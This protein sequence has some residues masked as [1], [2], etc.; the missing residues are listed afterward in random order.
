MKLKLQ[1]SREA[2]LLELSEDVANEDCITGRVCPTRICTAKGIQLVHESYGKGKFDGMLVYRKGEWFILCNYS[3][4]NAEGSTRERFTIAHELGHYH[5]PEH[6]RQLMG[7]CRPHGSHAGVFDGAESIEELEA[8]TFAANLLMPPLRFAPRLRSGKQSPLETIVALR[9]EFDTSLE[10]T[11][12]QVMRH[13]NR[14][15]AIAKWDED[16]LAWHRISDPFFRETGYRQFRLRSK[17]HL[18]PDCATV[19]ALADSESQFDS[20]IRESVVT[21]AHCFGHVAAGG[22]RDILLR[23]QAVRNGRFGVVSV[24]SVLDNLQ[25]SGTRRT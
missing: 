22:P 2:E 21:A 13:D 6:R 23:E 14:V 19:A 7:G 12:I 10:S 16:S 24:Y 15:V 8:D 18:A 4:G 9:K 1:L 5:I 25:A 11:A 3:S 17:A 20:T